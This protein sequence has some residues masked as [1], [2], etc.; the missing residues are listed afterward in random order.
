M[1]RRI[2]GE[3]REEEGDSL[4]ER[5]LGCYQLFTKISLTL[6]FIYVNEN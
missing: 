5:S 4:T 6:D 3:G 2:M 1:K